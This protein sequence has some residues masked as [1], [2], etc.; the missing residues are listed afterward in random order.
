LCASEPEHAPISEYFAQKNCARVGLTWFQG[1]I[2]FFREQ[3]FLLFFSRA[4]KCLFDFQ[5]R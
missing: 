2:L 4:E 5:Q 3:I 1:V